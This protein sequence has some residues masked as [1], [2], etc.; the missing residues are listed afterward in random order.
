MKKPRNSKPYRWA[1]GAGLAVSA[2][3]HGVAL[4][5]LAF[6]RPEP[7]AT[8]SRPAPLLATVPETAVELVRIEEMP[9][10]AVS[11][12]VLVEARPPATPTA[13]EELREPKLGE[14]PMAAAGEAASSS[15]RAPER[16][17]ASDPAAGALALRLAD[18]PLRMPASMRPSL[19]AHPNAGAA[20]WP[21][22]ALSPLS[23]LERD[24]GEG[25][26]K[27]SWWR[28]LGA[29]FGLGQGGDICVPRPELADRNDLEETAGEGQ[30]SG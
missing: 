16:P 11:R 9:E 25:E 29:K 20:A 12:P 2:A 15:P 5:T 4:A 1:L 8:E 23:E 6:P 18:A 3:L 19:G 22:R 27:R 10:P 13:S 14:A 28:R 21:L 7:A 17:A 26:E 24:E 30:G